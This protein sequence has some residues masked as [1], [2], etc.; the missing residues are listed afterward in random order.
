MVY[1]MS[2]VLWSGEEQV[3]E[4]SLDLIKSF[5]FLSQQV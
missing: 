3:N 1:D 2:I 4:L 5:D